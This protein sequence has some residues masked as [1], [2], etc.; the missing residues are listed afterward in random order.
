MHETRPDLG[1]YA[2]FG[3]YISEFKEQTQDGKLYADFP[4]AKQ[5]F[6]VDSIPLYHEETLD[7]IS[8]K[9]ILARIDV[10]EP[11]SNAA[12]LAAA[13]RVPQGARLAVLSSGSG[14][15]Q[16]ETAIADMCRVCP[17]M[18]C[19]SS[20]DD[21]SHVVVVFITRGVPDKFGD[22]I[23]GAPLIPIRGGVTET[24]KKGIFGTMS[25]IGGGSQFQ[26]GG[27]LNF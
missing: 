27:G 20:V 3:D 24:G 16:A 18:T 5:I 14:M 21:E 23:T 11:P 25:D 19:T 10:A 12:L 2:S 26:F 9:R 15:R 7:P 8:M 6:N 1:G 13:M 22:Q 4:E 17:T